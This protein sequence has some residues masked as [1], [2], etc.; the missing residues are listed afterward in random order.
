VTDG[1]PTADE[2]LEYTLKV[3]GYKQGEVVSFMVHLGDHLGLYEAMA[4]AGPLTSTDLAERTGLD[5]RWLLEW[6]HAQAAAGLVDR[7]PSGTFE[8]SDA[9]AVVL[10]Y[11][12]TPAFAGGYFG[13]PL[14]SDE[15]ERTLQG[16][17]TGI[18]Q[19]WEAHGPE[20]A[21]VMERMSA[22]LNRVLGSTIIPRLDG[23]PDKLAAGARVLDVGCGSGVAL[24]ELARQFPRSRFTGIDPSASAMAR[25]RENGADL[26]NV[27]WR[28]IPAE[29]LS[30]DDEFD[31]VLT[32]DCMH[33]MT[34]PADAAAA[35]RRA[36][37]DDA[38]WM[39]KDIKCGASFEENTWNPMAAM[40]YGMSVSFC[41]A[42]GL[43]EPGGAGLGTLGFHTD[44]AREIAEQAGFGRFRVHEV[45][46]DPVN[47]Y[48]EIRP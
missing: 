25:A 26:D 36:V 45:D 34:R 5:G 16:F 35:I 31:L 6:L 40:M 43:S 37:H 44:L 18:G 11:D 20:G 27:D 17:R 10:A 14:R 23:V 1:E 32:L 42:S 30:D 28:E 22:P 19:A 15:V 13:P 33:D 21:H 3:F 24:C 48:Y 38:T 47:N 41:M 8:L 4:G 7:S 29:F 2:V 12:S 9:G 39:V 46:V